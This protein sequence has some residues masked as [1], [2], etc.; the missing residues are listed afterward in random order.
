[1][2][3]QNIHKKLSLIGMLREELAGFL[4]GEPAYRVDQIWHAL[5]CLGAKTFDTITNIPKLLRLRLS[6]QLEIDGLQLDKS[7]TSVDGTQKWKLRLSDGEQIEA[8]LIPRNVRNTLCV[9]SQVGCPLGCKFCYT[10]TAR[11]R[12]NLEAKEIIGQLLFAKDHLNAWQ[13][14]L[15]EGE[16]PKIN[17]VVFMGMGEPLLNYENVSKAIKIMVDKKGLNIHRKRITLSTSGVIPEMLQCARELG[18][19]LALSLHATDDETRTSIMP[20]NR[21]YSII[22]L[23]EA[24]EEYVKLSQIDKITIEYIMLNNVNDTIEDAGRLVEIMGRFPSKVNLIPFNPW[25]EAIYEASS[26]ES[27]DRFAS[28]IKR[29]G[30][31][32]KIRVSKGQDI[33]AACG[34]LK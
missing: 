15:G 34:Q 30:Y 26:K 11:L 16:G 12:R 28:V 20:I 8:V 18:V 32:A 27:I 23:V 10:G 5:Y 24:C 13:S 9:S 31:I 33:L 29:A 21:K 6:E 1:M 17:N 2:E 19:C 25:P 22:E 4:D 3:T 7:L 14:P